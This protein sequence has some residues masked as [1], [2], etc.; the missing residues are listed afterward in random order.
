MTIID[1]T[2]K[3]IGSVYGYRSKTKGETRVVLTIDGE[4]CFASNRVA[5]YTGWLNKKKCTHLKKYFC[6]LKIKILQ[7]YL[8]FQ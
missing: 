1:S 4:T 2:W 6:P 7:I 3:V 5:N 8:H